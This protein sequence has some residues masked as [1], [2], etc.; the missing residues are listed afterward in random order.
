MD[1]RRYIGRIIVIENN[2]PTRTFGFDAGAVPQERT[3][4]VGYT[5]WKCQVVFTAVI[6][7]R[8]QSQIAKFDMLAPAAADQEEWLE[9]LKEKLFEAIA[10]LPKLPLT[11]DGAEGY[12]LRIT[13]CSMV[14]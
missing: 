4:V 11:E 6:G 1:S 10:N 8:K 9:M 7:G 2:L 13:E 3:T 5:T 14:I 12:Q